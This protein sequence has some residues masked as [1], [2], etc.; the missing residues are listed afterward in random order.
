MMPFQVVNFL[1]T[2][3][4]VWTIDPRMFCLLIGLIVLYVCMNVFGPEFPPE[5]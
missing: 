3:Y 2:L 5:D 4:N 1:H